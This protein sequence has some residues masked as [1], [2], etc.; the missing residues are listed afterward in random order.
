MIDT[1]TTMILEHAREEL[2]R[3]DAKAGIL[4]AVNGVGTGAVLNRLTV[5]GY[6][7]PAHPLLAVLWWGALLAVAVGSGFLIAAIKPRTTR[8]RGT[9]GV[10]IAY[11]ADV[12]GLSGPAELSTV[13]RRR[14]GDWLDALADQIWHVSRLCQVKYRYL[15]RGLWLMAPGWAVFIAVTFLGPAL[16]S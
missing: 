9:S 5:T 14:Q 12:R 1:H 16:S 15:S 7:A 3:A 10:P 2:G 13:L 6:P 11:F 8:G 4:L